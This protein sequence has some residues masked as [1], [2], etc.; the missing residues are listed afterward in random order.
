M[1]RTAVKLCREYNQGEQI[2]GREQKCFTW[3]FGAGAGLVDERLN[4]R[5]YAD[6]LQNI[7]N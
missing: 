7:T 6:S 3:F 1:K 4:I 2:K 5:I